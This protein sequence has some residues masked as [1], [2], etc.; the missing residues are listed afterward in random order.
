[1]LVRPSMANP[2][3][4]GSRDVEEPLD[5]RLATELESV[6]CSADIGSPW[7]GIPPRRDER[8][9]GCV[10]EHAVAVFSS[11]LDL[12]GTQPEVRLGDVPGQ[13]DRARQLAAQL[14]FPAAHGSFDAELWGLPTAGADEYSQLDTGLHQI[15]HQVTSEQPGSAGQQEVPHRNFSLWCAFVFPNA[16]ACVS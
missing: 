7:L 11:P 14:L 4:I 2:G 15:P 8:Q 3:H 1:M 12:L 13:H 16:T 5:V 9:A 6:L 10:V